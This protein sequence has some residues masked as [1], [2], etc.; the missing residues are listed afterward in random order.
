MSISHHPGEETLLRCAAGVLSAGPSL[1]VATHLIHCAQCRAR[2]EDFQR[3][4]GA[5]L[6]EMPRAPL[7][8]DAL[9]RTLEKIA[10]GMMPRPRRPRAARQADLG[11]TL[12]ASLRHCEIG[13][14]RWLG[15]GF[16]WSRITIPWSP[17]ARIMLL[18][19]RAGLKL[20][21]HGHTGTEFMEVLSGGLSDARGHYGPGDLD[22][23]DAEVDHQPV[24]D[25]QSE[26]ICLAALDGDT[27]LHGLLGRMLRPL[28][29]F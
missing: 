28:V 6:E 9:G 15:P 2:V 5:L 24:V 10:A 25:A 7:A 18:R 29:G 1:V 23:A 26:C 4:G 20:P 14:W 19:G 17:E 13:P 3:M 22:E 11:I 8:A 16:T 21:A 12:P 27:R